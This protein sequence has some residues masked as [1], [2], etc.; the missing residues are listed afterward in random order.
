MAADARQPWLE[1][2]P[3]YAHLI[4]CALAIAVCVILLPAYAWT[5]LTVG[6]T[7]AGLTYV[8]QTLLAGAMNDLDER[9]PSA[10]AG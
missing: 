8:A 10:R 5:I 7:V 1:M 6:A 9:H 2:M 4:G 3:D